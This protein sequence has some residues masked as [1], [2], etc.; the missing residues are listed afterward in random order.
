MQ[1]SNFKHTDESSFVKERLYITF[2]YGYSLQ[3]ISWLVKIL[4]FN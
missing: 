3:D 1:K 4:D 2:N